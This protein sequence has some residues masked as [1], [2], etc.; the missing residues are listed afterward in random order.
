MSNRKIVL[1]PASWV[2][3]ENN[4]VSFRYRILTD[5]FNIRSA[6]SPIYSIDAPQLIDAGGDGIFTSVDYVAT[7]EVSGPNTLIRLSWSTTPQYDGMRYFVFLND[8]YVRAIN[9]PSFSYVAT[10]A[11]SYT[12]KISLPNTTKTPLT[13]T[14]L[15]SA[16]ISV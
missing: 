9:V 8:E 14:I 6:H 10:T 3:D 12:F 2:L 1:N 4:K 15:F 7:K 11:G 16:T 13:N 5:D